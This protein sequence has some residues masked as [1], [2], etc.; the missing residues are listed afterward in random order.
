M[1]AHLAPDAPDDMRD[2][3]AG[4]PLAGAFMADEDALEEGLDVWHA[5]VVPD[6]T[7]KVLLARRIDLPVAVGLE[8]LSDGEWVADLGDL[9]NVCADH[10][11]TAAGALDVLA[12]RLTLAGET[13]LAAAALLR[14]RQ[15]PAARC[16]YTHVSGVRCCQA[17]L[18]VGLHTYRCAAP[19][20][21]GETWPASMSPHHNAPCVHQS[22]VNEG[23]TR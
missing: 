6:E 7:Q 15:D 19:G 1:M 3:L 16:T 18:H 10:S 9:A 23:A 14:G 22:T 20:C 17:P 11:L 5:L 12:D 21:P 13:L 2:A 8:H 4:H